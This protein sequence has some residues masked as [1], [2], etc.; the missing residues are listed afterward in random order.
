MT[1]DRPT[2][3]ARA[4]LGVERSVTGRRWV[5]RLD[6]AEAR[7]AVTIAQ[8]HALPDIVSRVL[9]GRG[10]APDD[11]PD[12]LDPALKR[13][14]PDPSVLTGM[15]AAAARIADA[16]IAGE[17]MAVFG[18]YDVDGATSS[19]LFARYMRAV[20]RDPAIYIPDRLFEGYGPNS[21]ALRT[22]A[23]AG[24]RLVVT[25]DCGS[26]S[27]HALADARSMGLDVVVID[28]HQLGAEL[29]AAVAVVNPNRQDDLSGLGH[30]AA[31]AARAFQP[32]RAQLARFAA[33]RRGARRRR[34][35]L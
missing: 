25:V 20:G 28:H 12:F 15:D 35:R 30:L 9:A 21:D 26:T 32:G 24:I 17:A 23:S 8:R 5:S 11:V 33:A 1:P 13:L 6:E 2:S 4:F 31:V 19:A 7:N 29:P 10:I 18:D 22:L 14:L 3:H 34:R 27:H 16:V